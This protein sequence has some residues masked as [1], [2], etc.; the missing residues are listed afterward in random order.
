MESLSGVLLIPPDRAHILS[1]PVWKTRYVVIGRRTATKKDRQNSTTSQHGRPAHSCD[2]KPLTKVFTD[3]YCISVFKHK[4]DAEPV[5]QWPTSCVVDCQVQM[6]TYR[7]QG[8]AMPTLIVTLSDKERKRRSTRAAGLI[9]NKESGASLWFRTPQDDQYPSLHEW[10]QFILSKK[11]PASSDGPGSSV[12]ASPFTPRSRDATEY[13]TRPGSGNHNNRADMRPLQH[14]SSSA[15]YSTGRERPATFSS[16]SPSLRSKRSD[17]SSPS[18]INQ[19]PNQKVTY[20]VGGQ[21]YTTVLPSDAGSPTSRDGPYQGDLIEGWTT[22]QGRSSTMSSP[23]R[24]RESATP[25]AQSM[26]L[27]VSAPPAPG[28]TIL[29]RAFQLGHIPGAEQ[30]IPG[31]EKFSSIARF[32]ALMRDLEEK[33]KQKEAEHQS[34]QMGLRSAFEA[35]DSEDEMESHDSDEEDDSD[36][37][38]YSADEQDH[39]YGRGPM[40]SPK[41]QRALDFIAGR[42]DE[43]SQDHHSH[44]PNM[45]RTHLSFHADPV[46]PRPQSPPMRPHTAHAKS[47]PNQSHRTQ[48]TPH[49]VPPAAN[50]QTEDSTRRPNGDSRY[51]GSSSK[52]LSFTEFTKRLSSTSSLLVNQTNPSGGSSRGSAEIDPHSTVTPRTNMSPRGTVPPPRSREWEEQD[53][54]CGWRGSVGVISEGGFL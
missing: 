34:E 47:R 6:V 3:E 15:T 2:T 4:E 43:P 32:D 38:A 41:A 52:R 50:R 54:G 21:H 48:S 49:L 46:P 20:T 1:K 37:D 35:D 42:H 10:A 28:E 7:K 16:D 23:T 22:A 40:I 33:Q 39:S 51:S 8:P 24:G 19:H 29:D 44:R 12:F 18:S 11:A 17:V 45:S 53:R 25:P 26:I 30:H 9:S 36:Y 5:H 31:Q 14:K 27:D 13:H